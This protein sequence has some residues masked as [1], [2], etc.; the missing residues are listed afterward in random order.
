MWVSKSLDHAKSFLLNLCVF[1]A[2]DWQDREN[3]EEVCGPRASQQWEF[4]PSSERSGHSRTVTQW[5]NVSQMHFISCDVYLYW[6]SAASMRPCVSLINNTNYP[7]AIRPVLSFSRREEK[8]KKRSG[9]RG[10][11]GME[12]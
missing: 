12:E 9:Q 11:V 1:F 2:F 3:I 4:H 7:A 5:P 10:K 8:R 6:C